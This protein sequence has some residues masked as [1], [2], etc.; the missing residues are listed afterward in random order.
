MVNTILAKNLFSLKAYTKLNLPNDVQLIKNKPKIYPLKIIKNKYKFNVLIIL[1]T[2]D[3]EEILFAINCFLKNN[4]KQKIFFHIK[5]HPKKKITTIH[6]LDN[7][8]KIIDTLKGS[9][10]LI[11]CSD[12]TTIS[13]DLI[14]TKIDF[15]IL[16]IE[17]RNNLFF[18]EY[19]KRL[20]LNEIINKL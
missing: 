19:N 18:N 11:L 13:Y 2:H 12:T 8:I 15:K 6:E 10:Q 16:E 5:A 1:G 7:R 17:N 3:T 9:F 20:Y 14:N 4:L